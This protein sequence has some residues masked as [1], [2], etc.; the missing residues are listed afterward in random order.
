MLINTNETAAQTFRGFYSRNYNPDPPIPDLAGL[1]PTLLVT[2]DAVP[3]DVNFDGSVD[4]FDV[5][6]VSAHWGES[7]PAGDANGDMTVDIF[8]IN[9]IS[10]NWNSGGTTAV[11]EPAAIFLLGGGVVLLRC[12]PRAG[13]SVFDFPPSRAISPAGE[14]CATART[15]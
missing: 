13:C 3:G 4:I 5:N 6:Q 15:R 1:L 14:R 8:D 12:L 9:L 11:P 2:F 7:G 10:S